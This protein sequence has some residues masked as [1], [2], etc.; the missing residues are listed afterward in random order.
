[1]THQNSVYEATVPVALYIAAV[2]GHPA[3]TAGDVGPDSGECPTHPTLVRLLKWLGDTAYDADDGCV[4]TEEPL[5]GAGNLEEHTAT[6]AFRDARPAIFSAVRAFLDHDDAGVRHTAL[7]DTPPWSDTRPLWPD[8][9]GP[10]WRP[11][12]TGITETASLTR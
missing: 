12:P 7:V 2:L 9:P 4:A 6:R 1:M 5:H 11:A 10:C 3:V 8:M